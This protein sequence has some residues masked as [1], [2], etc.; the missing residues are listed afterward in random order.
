M[1]IDSCQP[2]YEPDAAGKKSGGKKSEQSLMGVGGVP[3][4]WRQFSCG[5]CGCSTE[6][7]V[8]PWWSSQQSSS[9]P[10]GVRGPKKPCCCKPTGA[11]GQGVVS[12]AAVATCS[13]WGSWTMHQTSVTC[14][15]EQSSS[16]SFQFTCHTYI[17]ALFKTRL[18]CLPDNSGSQAWRTRD[19][20]VSI[21]WALLNTDCSYFAWR[22]RCSLLHMA[23]MSV[24]SK[25]SFFGCRFRSRWC[26]CVRL[27]KIKMSPWYQQGVL[28]VGAVIQYCTPLP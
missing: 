5:F 27:D 23:F 12:N 4:E 15:E 18:Y 19:R 9:L 7:A 8:E 10:A 22:G 1:L 24:L 2:V 13:C 3:W 28:N 16:S 21:L 11:A 25:S 26:S 6:K 20:W 17:E 14:Q